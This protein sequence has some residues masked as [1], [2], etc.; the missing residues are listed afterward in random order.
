MW[1]PFSAD[2]ANKSSGISVSCP[3]FYEAK[4]PSVLRPARS[5]WVS[6]SE[7]KRLCL[8]LLEEAS[9]ALPPVRWQ[10]PP[11]SEFEVVFAQIQNLI[12]QGQIDKAVPVVFAEASFPVS[13]QRKAHW[14]LNAISAPET[15][16]VHGYWDRG[17]G[18]LAA[19]PEILFELKGRSVS[20][21]AL[22]GTLAKQDGSAKDLERSTKDQHEHRLVVQDIAHQ[23]KNFGD[24]SVGETSVRELPTL[25]HLHTPLKLQL[26]R[27]LE[28]D[29]LTMALHP[30]AALGV[31]P[32]QFG[33]RWMQ[34]L[35]GQSRRGWFGSP[36]TF[37]WAPEEAVSLVSIRQLQ[38]QDDQVLLGSGCGLVKDSRLES[39]W[40][41][42]QR[43]RESVLRVLGMST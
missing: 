9:Q 36:I 7:L 43:K 24:V 42:L 12:A 4:K 40:T 2:E 20:T 21:M 33:W 5:E 17:A 26:D 18:F 38:W 16:Y 10:E 14:I 37:Q 27:P 31:S 6:L 32:R 28:V 22:A 13:A 1:G 8:K 25:W 35:P 39:E 11:R 3:K 41:E 29:Q 34:E 30:T 23:L 15:L 19:S